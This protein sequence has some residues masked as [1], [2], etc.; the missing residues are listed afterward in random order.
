MKQTPDRIKLRSE[1]YLRWKAADD[2]VQAL[3]ARG[4]QSATMSGGSGS[5]SYTA[6]QLRDLIDQRDTLARQIAT[7]DRGGRPNIQRVNIRFR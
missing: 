1:L 7:L 2:A 3:I 4:A 5:E 6:L